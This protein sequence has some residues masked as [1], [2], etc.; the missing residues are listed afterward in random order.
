MPSLTATNKNKY[1]CKGTHTVVDCTA[2]W[3]GPCKEMAPVYE[4]V[5]MEMKSKNINF[6]T[7]DVDDEEDVA[8]EYNVKSMPTLLF[9]KDG[10]L[11]K[12]HS[13][14]CKKDALKTM[15]KDAFNI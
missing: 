1:I 5:A 10:K 3:C 8:E 12:Q 6:M 13:G 4:E 15:V 7:L 9:F 2:T 14:K 11:V